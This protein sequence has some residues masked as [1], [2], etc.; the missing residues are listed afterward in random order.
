MSYEGRAAARVV[1]CAG[2]FALV[3]NASLCAAQT[4]AETKPSV[5]RAAGRTFACPEDFAPVARLSGEEFAFMRHREYDFAVFVATPPAAPPAEP[6]GAKSFEDE[7]PAAAARLLLEDRRPLKWKRM[8][9]PPKLSRREVASAAAQAFDGARRVFVEYH[10]LSL[11]G[12]DLYVGHV[13]APGG[14]GGEAEAARL[15]ALGGEAGSVVSECAV[16]DVV[17]ALTGEKV[18]PAGTLCAMMVRPGQEPRKRPGGK[19]KPA[20]PRVKDVRTPGR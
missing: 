10:R 3:L 4:Q 13:F 15:F 7:L 2:L 20:A 6:F 14:P 17:G 8:G 12:R 11:A 16:Q 18:D 19:V 9:P 1:R 5:C